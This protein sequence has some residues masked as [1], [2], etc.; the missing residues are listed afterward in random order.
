MTKRNPAA[1]KFRL[2]PLYL[3]LALVTG[4]AQTEPTRFYTLESRSQAEAVST[5]KEFVRG[6]AVGPVVLPKY[7]DRPQLVRRPSPY[8]VQVAE[9][10]RWAE[11]LDDM[12]ARVVTENLSALL[13]TDRVYLTSGP[14]PQNVAYQVELMIFRF[15]ITENNQTTLTTHWSILDRRSDR[16][17]TSRKVTYS[18]TAR[19]SDYDDIASAM[20]D[21]LAA[22]SQDIAAA[23][24]LRKTS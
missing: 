4:C 14:L 5:A 7:L 11:P 12:I 17:Q 15:D 24:S 9:F 1:S 20:S 16:I 22:L 3:V 21:N 23:L 18:E 2:V 10:D 13:A 8:I 6:I 19:S